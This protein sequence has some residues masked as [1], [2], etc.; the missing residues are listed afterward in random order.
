MV[1]HFPPKAV[2]L[3]G[4]FLFPLGCNTQNHEGTGHS[5][6]LKKVKNKI[7][8]ELLCWKEKSTQDW[9]A[10]KPI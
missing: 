3:S 4:F 8:K 9:V 7:L 10:E 2:A 5:K 1:K 6:V